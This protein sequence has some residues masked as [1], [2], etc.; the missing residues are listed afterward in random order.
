MGKARVA[1]VGLIAIQV[2]RRAA[3]GDGERGVLGGE[4]GQEGDR[5]GG[6][7]AVAETLRAGSTDHPER[8]GPVGH[9]VVGDLVAAER[10]R[11]VT[12]LH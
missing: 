2:Q 3:G 5:R 6:D 8:D 1:E 11:T 4:L 12:G 9:D 10:V 7:D